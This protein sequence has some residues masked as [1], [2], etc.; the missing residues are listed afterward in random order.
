VPPA[1]DV[2]IDD[3]RG[4]EYPYQA[5]FWENQNI[6]NRTS[7]DGGAA[8]EDP[9]IGQTNYA[10]VKIKNRGTQDATGVVVKGYHANPAAG[11]SFPSDWL[12][13]TT[14]QLSAPNVAAN[15]GAEITVGP[16]DWV[17]FHLGHECVIMIVSAT[18]DGSNVDNLHAGDLIPDW[19]LIPNDNNIGQ[20]NVAPVSGGG[21]SGLIAEFD[22]LEF[23][24]KNPL[25]NATK[26]EVRATLPP[27]LAERGWRLE[28]THRGGAAFPLQPQESRTVVMRMVA[29]QPFETAD[30]DNADEK[31]IQV[32]GYAGGILVG[33]LSYVLDPAIKHPRRPPHKTNRERDECAKRAERLIDCLDLE[34]QDVSRVRIRKVTVDIEFDDDC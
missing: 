10:Y 30:V 31:T 11:L 25:T 1:V 8:H 13:M 19:R 26:M 20:R 18:G 4:G 27:L 17:P 16:F 2:Y 15:N 29:G 32:V 34:P 12:P 22:S 33:G 5:V 3:G 7:A 28:F 21:T 9:I 24:L 14:A 23:E 6:W